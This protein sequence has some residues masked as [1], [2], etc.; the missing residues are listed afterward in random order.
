MSIEEF[1][2]LGDIIAKIKEI[3]EK[4]QNAVGNVPGGIQNIIEKIKEKIQEIIGS[5]SLQQIV[6]K[7][8]EIIKGLI[9]G[10]SE[11]VNACIQQQMPEITEIA[12]QQQQ[13]TM[14]CVVGA[15][16]ELAEL[17]GQVN[18]LKE[19]AIKILKNA[20]KDAAFCLI[21]GDVKTCLEG[22]LADT[23]EQG[24]AFIAKAK[25]LAQQAQDIFMEVGMCSQKVQQETATKL[26][27]V[28]KQIV[29][30]VSAYDEENM[31]LRRALY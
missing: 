3:I 8:V 9:G 21:G 31:I 5:G 10:A 2:S 13:G 20:G 24:R 29:S 23:R 1:V 26:Q 7:L 14:E 30:C 17:T 27:K 15:Q 12:Q 4:I 19:D 25:G 18:G 22:V 11:K 6:Q 16:S 28:Y